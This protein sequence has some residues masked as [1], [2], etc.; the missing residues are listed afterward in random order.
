MN[1]RVLVKTLGSLGCGAAVSRTVS[2]LGLSPQISLKPTRQLHFLP[3]SVA[4]VGLVD[5]QIATEA[6]ILARTVSP[7]A[8]FNHAVRTYIFGSMIGRASKQSFDDEILY[9]ACILHDLGLTDRFMGDLPFEIQGAQA[10]KDFLEANRYPQDRTRLIWDGIAMHASVIGQ[11][12]QPEIALVGAGAGMD[13]IGSDSSHLPKADIDE[14]LRAF[15]RLKLKSAFIKTCTDVIRQH[16]ATAGRTFMRD[17]AERCIPS[18]R[19]T[20]ICD[21][22]ASSPFPE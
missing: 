20:N 18:F 5:S 10:A 6:I 13:V 1:R 9:L 21:A 8:L 2:A 14:V 4:G 15:P 16:P 7:P 17:I 11:Y 22:I 3:R 19:S 12:K